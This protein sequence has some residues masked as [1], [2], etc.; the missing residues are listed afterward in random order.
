M[1]RCRSETRMSSESSGSA[2][3]GSGEFNQAQQDFSTKDSMSI[4]WTNEKHS[5]YLKSMEAS[6][7]NQLYS[8]MDLLGCQVQ[9]EM[10]DP[11]LS[12][13]VHCNT[14]PSGQFK[15]LR[16]G[17]W[18]KINFQ[19]S[20]SHAKIANEPRGLLINPWIQHYR[21]ARKPH[22]P[23]HESAA[24]QSQA[25][26][27][28]RKK[29]AASGTATRLK[30]SYLCRCYSCSQGLDSN[31]EVSDQNFVDEDV[32]SE[33]TSSTCGSKRTKIQTDGASS[34]DQSPVT[35]GTEN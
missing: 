20:D 28:S 10:S 15:V 11:K 23:L 1:D 13:Q 2:C 26:N 19:K 5:L 22:V 21:S 4:E 14:A 6:F 24:S 3:G 9:E 34:Y 35:A 17:C 33:K 30:H 27:L 7:V 31:K 8:S 12:Q 32:K 16:G 18:K 25:T 29:A